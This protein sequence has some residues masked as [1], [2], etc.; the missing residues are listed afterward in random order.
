MIIVNLKGGLGNQMFEYALGRRLS[1]ERKT[2]L[3]F[4]ISGFPFD[5]QRDYSLSYFNI[6]GEIATADKIRSL[7][8]PYGFLSKVWRKFK[9][10][11]LRV[12]NIGYEPQ[13]IL[14]GDNLYLDGYWQSFKYFENIR[15]TLLKDFSLKID[16]QKTHPDLLDQ[17]IKNN[18][19]ALAV[20]RTDYLLP[21]NL[22]WLGVCSIDYYKKAIELI[23]KKV[24]NP[25]FFIVCDDLTWVKKNINFNH[26]PVVYVSELRQTKSITDYQELILMSKCK[27]NIIANS[28]FSWWP[29]WLNTNPDKIV[30]APDIWFNNG[31]I[32]ID[33]IIPSTWIKLPRD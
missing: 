14:H 4:D 17:A 30:I 28:S 26:H 24:S 8:Y 16:L 1:L 7:K 29:A 33:D 20:R 9:F 11:I 23:E 10:K 12:H 27:H 21:E 6:T 5:H 22:K 19:V 31:N 2:S 15:E 18:S 13:N 3:K 32:K 25:I